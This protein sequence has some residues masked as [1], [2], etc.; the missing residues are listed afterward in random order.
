MCGIFGHTVLDPNEI[1]RSREA[2]HTLTH[3]GPDQWG[4]WH[5]DRVYLGHRRLSIIDLSDNARQPMM[6]SE[7]RTVIAANGEIYNFQGLRKALL[8]NGHKFKSKSDSE[9]LL[10]GYEEWGVEGL[11]ERIE[12]MF[13]FAIFKD[14]EIF[15]YFNLSTDNLPSYIFPDQNL[16]KSA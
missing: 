1:E 16:R 14:N 8:G 4:D 13:A 5:D 10:H 2:L 9:V 6:D 11:L 12:G 15:D 7:E 3:R